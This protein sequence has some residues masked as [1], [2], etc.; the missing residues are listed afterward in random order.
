MPEKRD[1]AAKVVCKGLLMD[2]MRLLHQERDD[3]IGSPESDLLMEASIEAMEPT[4]C[5]R[6]ATL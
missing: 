5:R 4:R 1:G 3:A 6:V 2:V